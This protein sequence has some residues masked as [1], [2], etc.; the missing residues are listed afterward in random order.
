MIKTR[1]LLKKLAVSS[2]T[3]ILVTGTCFY[4]CG[5][6]KPIDCPFTEHDWEITSEELI[7][8]EGEYLTS[9][10][11]TYGGTTYTY[12]CSYLDKDGT[13]KYM[14]D[15]D[16]ILMNVAWAYGSTD[17]D[18]LLEL[19]EKIH[20][21]IVE[22]YGKSGYHTESSTNYGDTW[23]MKEGNI[24]LSV[25]NTDSNKA[26]QIAYVNPAHEEKEDEKE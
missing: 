4:G 12:D 1:N 26:L 13:I 21:D 6:T 15:E 8:A 2:C 7:E 18:E 10:D 16:G 23:E 14:F 5:T 25:M 11:S 3:F 20:D 9:Y 22:N 19:Y 17:A 24:L